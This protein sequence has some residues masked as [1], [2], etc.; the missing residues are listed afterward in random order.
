MLGSAKSPKGIQ[1]LTFSLFTFII[2]SLLPSAW[3]QSCR[4]WWRS[5]ELGF[6]EEYICGMRAQ[7]NYRCECLTLFNAPSSILE[8]DYLWMGEDAVNNNLKAL[9][10]VEVV[11]LLPAF[12]VPQEIL[13]F[14]L[15]EWRVWDFICWVQMAEVCVPSMNAETGNQ[16]DTSCA[17]TLVV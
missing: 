3:Q 13:T 8:A 7:G 14:G 1:V 11:C 12:M 17:R 6:E 9:F 2:Q 10:V 5:T 15:R 4:L 16:T